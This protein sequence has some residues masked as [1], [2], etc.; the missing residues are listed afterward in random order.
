M[1]RLRRV[2]ALRLAV[3]A[4]LG[5]VQ[6]GLGCTSLLGI[7]GNYTVDTGGG[8]NSHPG[9]DASGEAGAGGTGGTENVGSGGMGEGG[10]G[11]TGGTHGS[12][13]AGGDADA[14]AGG[15]PADCRPGKYVGSIN[16]KHA[17]SFTVVAVQLT[18]SG[19]LSF[20]L[21]GTG[22]VLQIA[23]GSGKI[24]ASITLL[25]GAPDALE[26]TLTGSYDCSTHKLDGH[27]AGKVNAGITS[28]AGTLTGDLQSTAADD[29]VR[30]WEES[31]L[32]SS[33]MTTNYKGK[34]FWNAKY[35]G[36]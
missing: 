35:T 26:A 25:A 10:A 32:S 18:V 36:P 3:A 22:G 12:G 30:P 19:P 7:D 5:G 16:G 33:G 1:L 15:V 6:G 14:S 27:V 17:P 2:T 4:L 9:G 29:P 13:G 34:G 20:T 28:I 31:E 24:N 23:P 8:G 21:T 11:A